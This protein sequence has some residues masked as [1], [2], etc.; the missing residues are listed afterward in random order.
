[1]NDQIKSLEGVRGAAALVVMLFHAGVQCLPMLANGY[2]AVDLFFVLSGFVI[3][4]AYGE[5][6]SNCE[7]VRAFVVRRVGRLWPVYIATTLLSAACLYA[8]VRKTPDFAEVLA[9]VTMTHGFI[10]DGSLVGGVSWSASDEFYVYLV[11]G[12]VCLFA[13]GRARLAIFA[14]LA[15]IGYAIAVYVSVVPN[16]CV[17]RGEC[18]SLHY[19]MAWARCV[20]GF[21]VGVLVV[22]YRAT[23]AARILARRGPQLVIAVAA[24]AF[25]NAAALDGIALAA[26]LV[27]AA[28][29]ASLSTDYGPVARFF[30]RPAFQYLGRVSYTLYLVH[31]ALAAPYVAGL[32][33]AQSRMPALLAVVAG[34]IVAS[35][36]LAH[37]LTRFIE[38]PCRRRINAWADTA[39]RPTASEPEAS[40]RLPRRT[41][42]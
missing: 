15:V 24:L 4:G 31:G 13:R 22:Q 16:G 9:L 17:R 19:G 14:A 34:F 28:L 36:L 18:L 41:L 37:A 3:G 35:L 20:A 1:M 38:T 26:P 32:T 2:L 39:F 40:A 27:F 11:F 25:A 5:R 8:V 21:F 29:V 30:Q 7:A 10:L 23:R 6:L 33:A 12:A 42:A